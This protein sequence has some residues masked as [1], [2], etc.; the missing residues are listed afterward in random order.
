VAVKIVTDST[1]D[2]PHAMAKGVGITVVPLN[3]H[4][5]TEVYRDGVEILPDEFYQRLTGDSRLPT[6]SQPTVGDFLQSYQEL[7]QTT[8]EIV[9]VHI[10]AKLSGTL[11]SA[12][13]AKEQFQGDCRI[14]MVDSFTGSLGLGLIAKAANEAA[15]RGASIEEVVEETQLAIPRVQFFGLLDT[16][17]YLEEK[18]GRTGKRLRP[19]FG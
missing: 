2:L 7:S 17:E 16:L 13:Q 15:K 6:T 19:L 18:G 14:E 9:S 11:N 1:A 10:S 3:V 5:G 4:F 12:N 8:N